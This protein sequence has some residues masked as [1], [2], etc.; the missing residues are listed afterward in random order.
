MPGLNVDSMPT[1]AGLQ[2]W[3][4]DV[5]LQC[6]CDEGDTNDEEAF[7]QAFSITKRFE[8]IKVKAAMKKKIKAKVATKKSVA[9]VTAEP[10]RSSS[11]P[12]ASMSTP[13]NETMSVVSASRT[14]GNTGSVIDEGIDIEQPPGAMWLININEPQSGSIGNNLFDESQEHNVLKLPTNIVHRDMLLHIVG[15]YEAE[16]DAHAQFKVHC[17]LSSLNVSLIDIFDRLME[18]NGYVSYVKP[19]VYISQ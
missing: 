16:L 10:S 13:R 7:S 14:D 6:P 4:K 1:A 18:I 11:P 17:P 19:M 3:V 12:T 9:V 15:P 5:E 2:A 8:I